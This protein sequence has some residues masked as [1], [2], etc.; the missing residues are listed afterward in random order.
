MKKIL[1]NLIIVSLVLILS[2]CNL[3]QKKEPST[4]VIDTQV[5]VVLTSIPSVTPQPSSAQPTGAP[6]TAT[7]PIAATVT[8]TLES[9]PTLALTETITATAAE[10]P[11]ATA[12]ATTSSTDPK[13]TLGTVTWE[14]STF[15]NGKDFGF[16]D[17]PETSV[18]VKSSMLVLTAKKAD[19]FLGWTLSYPRPKDFYLEAT[20][21]TSDCS[22]ADQYGLVVRASD[23]DQSKSYFLGFSCDGRYELNKWDGGQLDNI[24]AWKNAAGF[25]S[26]GNQT[27][28]LGIMLKG[29]KISIYANGNLLDEVNDSTY[30]NAGYYGLYI[31]SANTDGFNIQLS[32]IAYWDIK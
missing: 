7:Q 10:I 23:Y 14:R 21:T 20:I 1:I 31:A 32:H 18:T 9:S 22:G 27:N 28:I 26:G 5:A 2:A 13:A 25:K 12:T 24:I 4:N 30:A 19:S 29:D 11:S 16:F 3:T 8:A 17:N 6:A 15:A